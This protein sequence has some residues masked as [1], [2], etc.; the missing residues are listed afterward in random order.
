MDGIRAAYNKIFPP[1]TATGSSP[2]P[3]PTKTAIFLFALIGL[4]TY[5]TRARKSIGSEKD[6]AD[7]DAPLGESRLA[8]TE[9][10]AYAVGHR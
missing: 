3:S 2:I 7:F 8:A 5:P 1:S 10:T 9:R 4:P 6:V